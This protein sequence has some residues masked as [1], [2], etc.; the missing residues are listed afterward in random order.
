M[1]LAIGFLLGILAS[2]ISA[3]VYEYVTRRLLKTL[4]D[5]S[6]RAQGQRPN[7]KP[8]EFYHLKV[9][10]LPTKW[11]LP[12]RKPG[13]SCKAN[14]EVFNIDGK[15]VIQYPIQARWT[16]QPEPLIPFIQAGQ[17]TNL[18][19][20]AKIIAGRKVDVHSHEDKQL[21]IALKFDGES[22]CYIFSNESYQ[23]SRW[24][25]PDWRLRIGTY[26]LRVTLFYERGR[27]QDYFE[28]SNSGTSRDDVQIKRVVTL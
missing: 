23:F 17:P 26:R 9:R 3:L 6:E 13:W 1:E 18:L 10:N 16:S 8:H 15:R 28:L 21:S 7:D 24:Q 22:E 11:I 19:D 5:D 4:L 14:I 25:N 12:G 27:S 2:G 20:P